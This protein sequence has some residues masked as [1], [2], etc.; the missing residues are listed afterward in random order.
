ME[1]IDLERV[2]RTMC[3]PRPEAGDPERTKQTLIDP[4]RIERGARLGVAAKLLESLRSEHARLA[5]VSAQLDDEVERAWAAL[6]CAERD[7]ARAKKELMQ[8]AEQIGQLERAVF[9]AR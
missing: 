9:G 1:E 8:R 4:E 7:A 6:E 3:E 5:E 2:K